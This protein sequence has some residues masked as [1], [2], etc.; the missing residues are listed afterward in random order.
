MP[1]FADN[2]RRESGHFRC[3]MLFASVHGLADLGRPKQFFRGTYTFLEFFQQRDD[4]GC[5]HRCLESFL[6]R[7]TSLGNFSLVQRHIVF[8]VR[9]ATIEAKWRVVIGARR[10]VVVGDV[11]AFALIDVVIAAE[12][13][14]ISIYDNK[15]ELTVCKIL[16]GVQLFATS[17]K[18]G[19]PP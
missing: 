11:P 5:W 16:E 14:E 10:W 3:S 4:V 9:E 7:R 17:Q 8:L 19:P 15:I 18:P 12:K 1:P 2:F 6:K 13:K